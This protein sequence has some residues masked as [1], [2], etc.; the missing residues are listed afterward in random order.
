MDNTFRYDITADIGRDF[1]VIGGIGLKVFNGYT[2]GVIRS[3]GFT[4][5]IGLTGNQ[6]DNRQQ[7]D[8]K[9]YEGFFPGAERY[10]KTE[11]TQAKET[12]S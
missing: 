4:I 5:V 10:G 7:R 11:E 12:S 6:E 3:T 1:P 2:E 9:F 8:N